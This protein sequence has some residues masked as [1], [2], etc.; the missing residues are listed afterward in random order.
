MCGACWEETF[1]QSHLVILYMYTREKYGLRMD[2]TGYAVLRLLNGSSDQSNSD[3][4]S[5]NTQIW[6][7]LRNGVTFVV[8]G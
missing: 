5:W 1:M 6:P 2:C 4:S 7:K 3:Y 8:L